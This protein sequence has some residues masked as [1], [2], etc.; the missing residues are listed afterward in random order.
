MVAEKINNKV[1]TDYKYFWVPSHENPNLI[2]KRWLCA[3]MQS[4]QPIIILHSHYVFLRFI[5]YNHTTLLK[6]P[7]TH[8]VSVVGEP[9]T[10]HGHVP[11]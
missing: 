5:I 7:F 8:C 10:S 6:F 1:G 9:D 3:L 11:G 2:S 4:P